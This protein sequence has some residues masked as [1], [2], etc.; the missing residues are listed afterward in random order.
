MNA[1]FESYRTP[2]WLIEHQWFIRCHWNLEDD[3]I[4]IYLYTLPYSFSFYTY[5]LENSN[6]LTKS[7][8]P[9]E[10]D[11]CSYDRVTTLIQ[12]HS[13]LNH[14]IQSNIRFPNIRHLELKFPL[15]DEFLS[16]FPRLDQLISLKVSSHS[17]TDADIALSQLQ[18]VINRSPRLYLLTIALWNSSIIKQLPLYLTS[19]S[20]RRLDLQSY[21]YQIRDR[22][23]N[24][25][26]CL[27][28]VQSSLAKQ[29]EVLQIV[30]D[31]QLSIG[32]LSNGLKNLRALKVVY[33]CPLCN[34]YVPSSEERRRWIASAFSRTFTE[35]FS[36][37]TISR[38]WIC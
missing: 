10:N 14:I 25:E 26:E 31:N 33:Q 5:V 3:K 32:H 27:T 7:T 16:I 11:Y 17:E 35:H 37:T 12:F 9:N 6:S 18:T 2:F 4:W 38:L 21:H 15:S 23:F 13:T 1:M 29:C 8:C 28:F 34:N 30:V 24:N 20:I 19:K 36:A 22:C